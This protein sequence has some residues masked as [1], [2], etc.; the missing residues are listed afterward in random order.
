M[1][2]GQQLHSGGSAKAEEFGPPAFAG[3]L[4]ALWLCGFALK[5]GNRVG[6]LL[7]AGFI[8]PALQLPGFRGSGLQNES[9]F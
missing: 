4:A 5:P 6:I 2:A 1:F 8:H 7:T 9:F 3:R